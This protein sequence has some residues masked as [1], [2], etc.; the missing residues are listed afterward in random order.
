MSAIVQE[1]R[2]VPGTAEWLT[3]RGIKLGAS[4]APA[5]M[6]MSRYVS[7]REIAERKKAA[8]AGTPFPPTPETPEQH[9]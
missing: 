1:A 8:I 7:P 4:D 6:G 3:A 2:I 9:R 5:A